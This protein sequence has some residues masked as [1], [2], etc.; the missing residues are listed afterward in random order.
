[1]RDGADSHVSGAAPAARSGMNRRMRELGPSLVLSLTVLSCGG[2]AGAPPS[3]AP[4]PTP[5]SVTPSDPNVVVFFG[6]S[7][8][9]VP[10]GESRDIAVRYQVAELTTALDVG[11]SFLGGSASAADFRVSAESVRI[12]PGR[13]MEGT[14]ELSLT[15]ITDRTVT[16]GDESLTVRFV[17][18][19]GSSV[20]LI[21]FG[22]ALEVVI[23]DRG[24]P[25]PGTLVWGDPPRQTGDVAQVTLVMD[26]AQPARG[27]F[28]WAGPYY[29]DEDYPEDR[30]Q[31]PLLEVNVADWWVET[32]DGSTR[33]MLELE[34]P[35]FLEMGLIFHSDRHPCERPGLVCRSGGCELS[36]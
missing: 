5:P 1:M 25:C 28:D 10:E 8:L 35:S 26:W 36:P 6:V 20:S 32:S 12:P 27:G 19:S 24:S 11:I 13:N 21:E 7:Q 14:V 17:R 34:W 33:H 30:S 3:P 18:P 9:Q 4:Q 15:A 16:E 31:L 23:E 2:D 22:P 29:D